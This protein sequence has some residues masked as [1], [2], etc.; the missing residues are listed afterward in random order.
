MQESGEVARR[1][2]PGSPCR[3][4]PALAPGVASSPLR[5]GP[6]GAEAPSAEEGPQLER[7]STSPER[8]STSLERL[9]RSLSQV[10]IAQPL[11]ATGKVTTLSKCRPASLKQLTSRRSS[12]VLAAAGAVHAS[13]YAGLQHP[14]A[15][16]HRMFV[17]C[18][19]SQH[20]KACNF[21][22]L[23]T[24]PWRLVR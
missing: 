20:S 11:T 19:L 2:P 24:Y 16:V 8:R 3:A 1:V 4:V 13:H 15:D 17:V 14:N 18:C 12:Q 5:G 21:A 23:T 6:P 10:R 22:A 9:S 7:Q